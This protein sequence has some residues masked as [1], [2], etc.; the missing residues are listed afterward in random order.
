MRFHSR[1][2]PLIQ[3]NTAAETISTNIR[4]RFIHNPLSDF[5]LVYNEVRGTNGTIDTERSLS[6]KVTHLVGF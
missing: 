6:L 1:S 5:F 2:L 3:Y 4:Y